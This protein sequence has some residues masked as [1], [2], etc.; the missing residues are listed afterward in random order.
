MPLYF[1]LNKN[2][3][4]GR[5]EKPLMLATMPKEALGVVNEDDAFVVYDVS[6]LSLLDI[7]NVTE[8]DFLNLQTIFTESPLYYVQLI[9]AF[10]HLLKLSN[11]DEALRKVLEKIFYPIGIPSQI[12]QSS[13]ALHTSQGHLYYPFLDELSVEELLHIYIESLQSDFIAGHETAK[14]LLRLDCIIS[15]NAREYLTQYDGVKRSEASVIAADVLF[16]RARRLGDDGMMDLEDYTKRGLEAAQASAFSSD[17]ALLESWLFA[18]KAQRDYCDL[19]DIVLKKYQNAKRF[20]WVRTDV[21]R[22][23]EREA[24][25]QVY[26]KK[27]MKEISATHLKALKKC[28]KLHEALTRN[29]DDGVCETVQKLLTQILDPK[30]SYTGSAGEFV[31]Q[32]IFRSKEYKEHKTAFADT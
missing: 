17:I 31:M 28:P 32:S 12:H 10:D 18:E 6:D 26:A 21:F 5:A 16:K 23:L 19:I 2:T 15:V 22:V 1:E 27:F 3:F 4:K 14:N 25:K 7:G 13:D 24:M 29:A 8:R 11:E 30:I 9:G 20:P